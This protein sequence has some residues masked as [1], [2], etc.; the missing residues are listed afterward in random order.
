MFFFRLA[1][2]KCDDAKKIVKKKVEIRSEVSNLKNRKPEQENACFTAVSS[3]T[4]NLLHSFSP[5]LQS[6][7]LSLQQKTRHSTCIT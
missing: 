7:T 5:R 2:V 4:K 3:K 1:G 6:A